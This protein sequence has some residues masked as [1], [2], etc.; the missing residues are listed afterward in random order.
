MKTRL[1]FATL[2]MMALV[3]MGRAAVAS[4][5]QSL[6]VAA[7]L[8]DQLDIQP[9]NATEGPARNV[10]DEWMQLGNQQLADGAYRQAIASWQEAASIYQALGD[11]QGQGQAYSAIGSTYAQ[12]GQYPQAETAIRL[13]IATARDGEDLIGASYGLN[14]LGTLYLNR[15]QLDPAQTLYV[16]ALQLAQRAEDNRTIGLSLSNLGLVALQRDNFETAAELLEA[17]TNYRYLAGDYLGEANSSNTLGDVYMA[18]GRDGNAIGAYRVALRA[19]AQA[20]DRALQLRALDGLLE[21]YFDRQE[22]V[23]VLEYLNR[24]S[25]L[26]LESADPDLQTAVT[27][28]WLGDYFYNQGNVADAEQAYSRGLGL[29]RSLENPQ[30]E[31]EL[32]NRILEL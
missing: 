3:T 4:P 30:L 11:T 16:E 15:A 22:W 6:W 10:A 14:N 8:E 28:R 19:G 18:L 17:A 23:T 2:G 24:R 7:S 9:Y 26:T 12:L 5:N 25:E 13:R 20:G 31:A 29:A 21:I 1:I 27:L 32:T